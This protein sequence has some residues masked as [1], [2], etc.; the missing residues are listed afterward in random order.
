[1]H[2]TLGWATSIGRNSL[3]SLRHQVVQCLLLMALVVATP[4][5]AEPVI[6]V[7]DTELG[8]ITL[9]LDVDKAPI[10]ASYFLDYIDRGKYDG[11]TIYRAASL[12]GAEASQLIQGGLL[13]AEL[14][15]DNPGNLAAYGIETLPE[16]ET[17]GQSGLRHT[18]GTVS[19]ARDL[20]V[21]GDVIPELVIY[22]RDAPRIDENGRDWPDRRGFPAIGQV[23]DGMDIVDAISNL[24]CAGPTSIDFLKGQILTEPV[25]IFKASR[26]DSIFSGGG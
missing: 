25:Q 14:A 18:R 16:F 6:V 3:S 8:K 26:V 17:T 24:E 11:A 2:R 9:A 1:M 7:L 20:L 13:E 10:A 5:H 22:Q 12:D 19:L 23:I 15:V 4:V 21:S